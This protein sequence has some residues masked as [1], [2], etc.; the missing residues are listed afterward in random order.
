MRGWRYAPALGADIDACVSPLFDVVSAR[1]RA[2]L[3][4]NPVNSIHLAVPPGDD[5]AGAALATLRRWKAG[6]VLRQDALPGIYAYYQYFRLPGSAR[7]YCRKGFM[8]HIRAYD[9]AAGVVL[10]HENTL[11][12]SVHDRAALLARTEFQTSATHGLYRDDAFELE[13]YLDEAMR[14]PLYQTEDDYQGARDV[15]A[16]VQDAAVIRRFQE[17]L[18]G[19]EVILADGHHRYE[20]SLA[21]RRARR[22]QAGVRRHRPRALELPPHVPHQRGQRRL[23]HPAHPPP[24]AGPARGPG[25]RAL[26]DAEFLARL[27]PYFAVRP[28]EEAADLPEVIAGKRWAFGLYVG[29]QAYKLRLRPE[30]HQRWIWDTTAEV[31]NLDLTVLHFF[32]LEKA[33][34]LMGPDAQRAWPGVAY[35]RSFAECLQRVDRG[36]ACAA[37]VVNEVTM[38]EVEAVCRSG[39]VMPAKSTFFYPKTLAGFLFSSTSPTRRRAMRLTSTFRPAT[40][41]PSP[42]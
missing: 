28:L 31:K 36:E 41:P 35:V 5:P 11:P 18:A 32:V 42:A 12:A 13:A 34:G 23:A 15:L 16:V 38:A 24:A 7:A 14:S 10:R 33:L 17:V 29:G 40:P 39:A 4:R 8:C 30:A 22:A 25:G 37:L 20:G 3:Y 6:G 9:W 27:E 1:Q 26:S 19:R 2:A 21:H